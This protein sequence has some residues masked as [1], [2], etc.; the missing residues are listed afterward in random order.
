MPHAWLSVKA[1]LSVTNWFDFSSRLGLLGSPG[2]AGIAWVCWGRLPLPLPASCPTTARKPREPDE[3]EKPDNVNDV[4]KEPEEPLATA[5]HAHK[6]GCIYSILEAA[7]VASYL[8][9][10]A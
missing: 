2:F 4:P 6:Q 10:T 3:L 5:N 1:F 8:S 7:L 9:S